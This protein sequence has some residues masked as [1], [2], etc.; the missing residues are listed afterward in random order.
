MSAL[1]DRPALGVLIAAACIGLAVWVTI[2][3]LSDK[4]APKLRGSYYLD[5]NAMKLFAEISDHSPVDAPSGSAGDGTPA[6][7]R[8]F[9]VACG[10]VVEA[11]GMTLEELRAQD[12]FVAYVERFSDE[13]RAAQEEIRTSSFG[14]NDERLYQLKAIVRKGHE[15]AELPEL[16]WVGVDTREG[17]DITNRWREGCEQGRP[18]PILPGASGR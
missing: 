14:D 10:N 13:A 12:A 9:V 3:S 8:A 11:D 2:N 16:N 17:Y 4:A 15:V 5:T 18:R 6:G 7:Y 1:E